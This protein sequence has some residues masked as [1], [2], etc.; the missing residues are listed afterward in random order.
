MSGVLE[1]HD[2]GVSDDRRARPMEFGWLYCPTMTTTLLTIKLQHA[3]V[4]K[5]FR[6][7]NEISARFRLY[8]NHTS[9]LITRSR[10]TFGVLGRIIII[11][12][13]NVVEI[14]RFPTRILS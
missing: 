4:I 13:L 6:T 3:L 7:R 9:R 10:D 14:T 1:E 2:G 5:I 12:F 11:I 8:Y